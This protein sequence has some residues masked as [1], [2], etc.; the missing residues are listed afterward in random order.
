MSDDGARMK[1]EGGRMNQEKATRHFVCLLMLL[2]LCS[3]CQNFGAG[4][5][6]EMVVPPARLHDAEAMD[7]TPNI[8]TTQPNQPATWPTTLASTTQPVLAELTISLA[9]ARR[10]A[11]EN[12][13]DLRVQLLNPTISKT[14]LSEAEAQFESL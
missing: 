8:V 10:M 4:G 2:A 14:S 5:T 13:L 3:S 1:D 11:L 12:N 7:L 9:E 6:G